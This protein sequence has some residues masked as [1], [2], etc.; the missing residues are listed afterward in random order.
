VDRVSPYTVFQFVA[1]VASVSPREA[2]RAP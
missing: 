1:R 2:P